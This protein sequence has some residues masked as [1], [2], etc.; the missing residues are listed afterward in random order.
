MVVIPVP[1]M[2]MSVRR[3]AV[4]VVRRHRDVSRVATGSPGVTMVARQMTG[5]DWGAVAVTLAV[6]M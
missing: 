1:M 4:V 3:V 5:T 2:A 6:T